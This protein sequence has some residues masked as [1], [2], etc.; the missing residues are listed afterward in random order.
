MRFTVNYEHCNQTMLRG[1]QRLVAGR[2][3]QMLPEELMSSAKPFIDASIAIGQFADPL[4]SQM[5]RGASEYTEKTLGTLVVASK[6][7]EINPEASCPLTHSQGVEAQAVA[8]ALVTRHA[9]ES[10]LFL[11]EIASHESTAANIEAA[12]VAHTL[13]LQRLALYRSAVLLN[14]RVSKFVHVPATKTGQWALGV[15]SDVSK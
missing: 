14:L 15:I 7:C 12:Y 13:R 2:L 8:I 5:S 11:K 3:L 9:Y 6:H 4:Y 10:S 1:A